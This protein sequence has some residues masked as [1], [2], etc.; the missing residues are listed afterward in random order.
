VASNSPAKQER[1]GGVAHHDDEAVVVNGVSSDDEPSVEWGWH[2]HYPK[3]ARFAG[4]L[5][6]AILLIMLWGNHVGAQEDIWLVVLAVGF[7]ALSLG[8]IIRARTSWR[9]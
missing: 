3:L 5:V 4:F 6:A 7:F 2:A 8:S 9:R 1:G